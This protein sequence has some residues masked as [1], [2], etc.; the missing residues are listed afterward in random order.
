MLKVAEP[1]LAGGIEVNL[2]ARGKCHEKVKK[3]SS[4]GAAEV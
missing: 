4:S 2:L 1:M 3:E